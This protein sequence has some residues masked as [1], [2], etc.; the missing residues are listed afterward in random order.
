MPAPAPF[1][2]AHQARAHLAELLARLD[3]LQSPSARPQAAASVNRFL[4]TFAQLPPY[5]GYK[6]VPAAARR[7]WQAVHDRLGDAASCEFLLACLLQAL[8]NSLQSAAFSALPARVQAHQ[9]GQYQRMVAGGAAD[10]AYCALDNDLFHKEFG[11]ASLRLYAAAAQ[12]V[13]HR[14]GV[15]M[16]LLF[17]QGAADVPRRLRVFAQL[18]GFKP[19]FQ[20]HTHLPCL[21]A[22]NEAG[23]EE[24]YRCCAELYALHPRV[25]GMCGGSWFFD[26]ALHTVSPRLRYL[27]ETPL[28]GGA[29]LLFN[30]VTSHGIADAT[31]TS[32]TRKQLY[33]AGHYLPTSY[34]LLWPRQAQKDWADQQQSRQAA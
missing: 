31:A 8:L 33:E 26:P 25:L 14:S 22:F 2:L 30:A 11:L 16:S 17:K 19:L 6:F 9:L 7:E 23:W 27:R 3:R 12:L 28:Q 10:S 1:P 29:H 34:V 13:D 18:G 5:A 24:C 32:P 21:D 15:G 20:I 4:A